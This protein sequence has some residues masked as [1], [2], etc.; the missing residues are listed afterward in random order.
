M[1]VKSDLAENVTLGGENSASRGR[2][3]FVH[4][5]MRLSKIFQQNIKFPP[6]NIEPSTL[7]FYL[8]IFL[9]L[10]TEQELWDL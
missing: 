8:H 10:P 9:I 5:I 1:L 2:N 3:K 7:V 6:V 4:L